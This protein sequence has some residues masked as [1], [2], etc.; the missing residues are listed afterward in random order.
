MNVFFKRW[1]VYTSLIAGLAATIQ[2]QQ[3]NLRG[4]VI[5]ESGQ[6]I[7]GAHLNLCKY[8][9]SVSTNNNGQF[10]IVGNTA[11]KYMPT[12]RFN[13]SIGI[14]RKF[15]E[16]GSYYDAIVTVFSIDGVML[17]QI[18]VENQNRI[19]IDQVVPP[20]VKSQAVIISVASGDKVIN[21]KSIRCES[22][23]LWNEN[24]IVESSNNSV[25]KHTA[26]VALDTLV[27][28]KDGKQSVS[29]FV[30]SLVASMADIVM[31]DEGKASMIGAVTF[32]EPSKTFK[33]NLSVKLSTTITNAEIRYTIDGLPP[34]ASSTLYNGNA[35]TISQTTQLRAAA[36]VAGNLSG[37]PSTAIYIARTFDFTSSIP[38]IIMEGY[39]KGKPKDKYNF[40]DLAFMTFEPV[41]GVASLDNLPTLVTRAGYHLRGQ[42]SMTAFKQSPYRIELWDNEN[43][44]VKYPV[45][46]MPQSSDWAL[47][48]TCTDNSLIRNVFGVELGKAFGLATVQ[49]RWA[50]VFINY[51]GGALTNVTVS[52]DTSNYRGVYT[53]FQPIKNDKNT[54]DLKKLK[55]EDT[56]PDKL[57]GAYI[58]KFE[59]AVR[60]TDMVL[61]QCT[62]AKKM[63][64]GGFGFPT[65]VDSTA[66]CYTD[67]ELAEPSPANSQQMTYITNY[68]QEFHNAL[69]ANPVGN[70]KSYVNMNSFINNHVL[71]EISC[72]IDGW[73]R[74][75]YMYK[76]RGGLI[77]AGPVWDYNFAF[78]NMVRNYR[79]WNVDSV[80]RG[81]GD[82]HTMMW[83]QPEY[84][85]AYKARYNE[86]RKTVLTDV[87]ID[88]LIDDIKKPIEN[89]AQR[90]F[91]TFPM[92][93]CGGQMMSMFPGSGIP[94]DKTWT[95]HID[96]LKIWTKFR[97]KT[98]DSLA[99]TIP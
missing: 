37:K 44:D 56:D 57:T 62:G 94:K 11:I 46:G 34:T 87:A 31:Y 3:I 18:K 9:Y 78:G 50:E 29:I 52:K 70:W 6:P 32:S 58:F 92:G 61:I 67:L 25:K 60:D 69:H 51:D 30:T 74:S 65:K 95:G 17:N 91:E 55:P 93:E 13:A 83:K 27:V 23:W 66:T 5:D 41:N 96:S 54:I 43:N 4:K 80:R 72:N 77:T 79:G 85:S 38:I 71:N 64:G 12:N 63:T 68:I 84:K 19:Q 24:T 10:E 99:A 20:S 82:W 86:L 22:Q 75:H 97:L 36:F 47:I 15:L 49:Y 40:I 73:I 90:N 16:L 42:S 98:L 53:L 21:I 76:D 28:K 89:V 14:N 48:S 26:E 7:A 45:L 35:I 33:T 2:A 39:G 59:N 81:S 1:F 88:K 8:K